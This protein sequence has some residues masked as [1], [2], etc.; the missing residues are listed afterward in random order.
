MKVNTKV[1][2]KSKRRI[3]IGYEAKRR[4]GIGFEVK[5]RIGLEVKN[6]LGL[7]WK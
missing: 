4:I 3:G 5:R 2:F 7:V 1:G 6:R